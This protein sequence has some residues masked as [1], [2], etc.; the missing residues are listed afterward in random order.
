MK[1]FPIDTPLPG[2][3]VVGVHPVMRPDTGI[4]WRSRL[5][6]WTGRALTAEA[7][8]QE[9]EHRAALLAWRGRLATAGVVAGLDIALEARPEETLKAKAGT[10]SG[11]YAHVLPGHGIAATGEDV[12]IPRP[13]RLDLD[14]VPVIYA[15]TAKNAYL[16]PPP[17]E[18]SRRRP[19]FNELALGGETVRWHLLEDHYAPWAAVLVLKPVELQHLAG[20]ENDT[21]CTIDESHEAFDDPRRVDASQFLLVM[22]PPVLQAR[23][24]LKGKRADPAWRNRVATLISDLEV[25]RAAR[26]ETLRRVIPG[27]DPSW[28]TALVPG[29]LFPWEYF[30]VPLALVGFEPQPGKPE[31]PRRLFLDRASVVRPG[32]RARPRPR[33]AVTLGLDTAGEPPGTGTPAV[34]QSR[35][36]Q[37]NEHLSDLLRDDVYRIDASTPDS[38]ARTK[39]RALRTRFDFLPPAG[40][41]PRTA[42]HF[43]TTEEARLLGRPDRADTS[44]FFPGGFSARAVP[45]VVDE[46]EALL[47]AS[48]PLGRYDLA[49]DEPVCVLVPLPQHLFDTNLL[50]IEQPDPAFLAEFDRLFALR[51]G[52]RQRR[53][54]VWRRSRA[55][56][57]FIT[58]AAS[59]RSWSPSTGLE[60]EPREPNNASGDGYALVPPAV[61]GPWSVTAQF[62][63][64]VALAN[65]ASLCVRLHL[66]EE[67]PPSR[68]TILWQT[69]AGDITDI[70]ET[71]PAAPVTL[72]SGDG[73]P[74]RATLWRRYE[75]T[76]AD[77]GLDQGAQLK[78]VQ[79]TFTGGRVAVGV[80]ESVSVAGSRTSIWSPLT[81]TQHSA[82]GTWPLVNGPHIMAPF[83]PGYAPTL[84]D[85]TPF[86]IALLR[87]AR[88]TGHSPAREGLDTIIADL[89][90]AT[91]QADDTV[92]LAF[93]KTRTKIHSIRQVLLGRNAADALLASPTIGSATTVKPAK[94]KASELSSRF[95]DVVAAET[96][97]TEY[98]V[99]SATRATASTAHAAASAASVTPVNAAASRLAG[100]LFTLKAELPLR[101]IAIPHVFDSGLTITAYDEAHAHFRETLAT[102]GRL[103]LG[104]DASLLVPDTK[105]EDTPLTFATLATKLAAVAPGSSAEAQLLDSISVEESRIQQAE[106]DSPTADKPAQIL[107]KGIRRTDLTVLLLRRVETY[108][109]RRRRLI[110]EGKQLRQAVAAQEA[111]AQARVAVL[112]GKLAESRH[113]M[114][115]AR[116]LW[117]E[118]L[119]RV[120]SLNARRDDLLAHQVP[121][122]AFIRPRCIDLVRRDLPSVGCDRSDELAPIPAALSDDRDPPDELERY[123]ALFRHAPVRWFRAL[124]PKLPEIATRERLTRLLESSKSNSARLLA[125]ATPVLAENTG[126]SLATYKSGLAVVQ[127]LS[128]R[129]ASM[130]VLKLGAAWE[131]CLRLATEHATLG[132]I[133]EASHG[134]AVL[135]RNAAQEFENIGR[136][137]AAL[138]AEFAAMAPAIRLLWVERYSQFDRPAP[139]RDVTALP[140]AD[141]LSSASRE[142]FQA[143]LDWL[144]DRIDAAQPGAV[145]IISDLVRLCLLLA[146]HAPVNRLILGH[147][148]RPTPISPGALIPLRPVDMKLVRAGMVFHVWT[149]NRIVARGRV[150]DLRDDEISA[151]VEEHESATTTL[152]GNMQVQ[153]L[154]LAATTT[155]PVLAFASTT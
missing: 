13:I 86:S 115:V 87:F 155:Q 3:H 70:Q 7:L 23:P 36:A 16:V 25:E 116:A 54:H 74:A 127:Q 61:R 34:W 11:Y 111:A 151:R 107:A 98:T 75:R 144:F 18:R 113:D 62:P 126:A 45:V 85:D 101:T 92:T 77:L 140:G 35:V 4:D 132:D 5:N 143:Y 97:A 139:L 123:L 30:G 59:V 131:E 79:L 90:A 64:P 150:E 60:A 135:A 78:S 48:A 20:R 93:E 28:S 109:A 147:V 26:L 56:Q 73:C 99:R 2:E 120:D 10:L 42:L 72:R 41:L 24:L 80:V 53:D 1:V 103:D 51:Q 94:I 100:A 52:W 69:S 40:L 142:N 128:S 119:Q 118:E 50:V 58:G 71:P 105:I 96:A 91:N 141:S 121:Q 104:Y 108:I 6:F 12:V 9:Q 153:F 15:R 154:S 37:F 43:L 89:E 33:P 148:L 67:T 76:L 66:D 84:D 149:D 106:A 55:M 138:H 39:L 137:A 8:D 83:E 134:H 17:G 124:A 68:V 38:E 27:Q 21:P 19:W 49:K 95:A 110:A 32:G 136:V 130:P 117:L 63:K 102:I 146:S 81:G 65:S 129:T 57:S 112:E 31:E 47:A 145:S 122:L 14:K 44:W 22:V 114:S 88:A 82:Q 29:E 46:V 133:V 125:S 152:D